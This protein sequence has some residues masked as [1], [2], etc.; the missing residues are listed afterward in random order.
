MDKNTKRFDRIEN[1]LGMGIHCF[2]GPL[3]EVIKILQSLKIKAE[4]M[5]Y[6]KLSISV[7]GDYD[8][9]YDLRISVIGERE[10]TDKERDTRLKKIIAQKKH[11]KEIKAKKEEKEIKEYNR[12]KKKFN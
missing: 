8:S 12:L 11:R 1:R 10:E 3:D 7:D 9:S 4:E 2:N 5:G 6:E